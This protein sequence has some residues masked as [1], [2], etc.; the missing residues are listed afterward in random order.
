MKSY[1]TFIKESKEEIKIIELSYYD[2]I[3]ICDL[4]KSIDFR[5]QYNNSI[6]DIVKRVKDNRDLYSNISKK[7]HF[8]IAVKNEQLIGVFY[9]QLNGNIDLYDDGYIISKGAGKE[10]LN[11][12]KNLGSFTTFTNIS[13]ISS[14][15]AQIEMGAEIICICDNAPN[16]LT[17]NYN[18]DFNDISLKKAMIDEKLFYKDGNNKFFIF[19]EFGN[20]K[21]KEFVNFI[22]DNDNIEIKE[23]NKN[24]ASKIKIYFLFQK[25]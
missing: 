15:K 3:N 4:Y 14:L 17:G 21:K 16:K 22:N 13:N 19:D 11:A 7:Y 1:L 8:L 2:F 9:K 12:M 25:K 5:D 23:P 18:K 24:M 10:L 20:F 6:C